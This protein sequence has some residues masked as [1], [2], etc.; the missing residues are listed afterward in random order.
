MVPDPAVTPKLAVEMRPPEVR[1]SRAVGFV[2]VNAP[3]IESALIVRELES[4]AAPDLMFAALLLRE[5][6]V[7]AS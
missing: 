4:V 2:K 3:V 7:D 5:G 6:N 1:F